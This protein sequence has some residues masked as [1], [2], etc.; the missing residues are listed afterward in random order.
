MWVGVKQLNLWLG[1]ET[2]H[3]VL[4]SY[5]KKACVK[6]LLEKSDWN[7]FLFEHVVMPHNVFEEMDLFSLNIL[8]STIKQLEKAV[9]SEEIF[10]TIRYLLYEILK[11]YNLVFHFLFMK[12]QFRHLLWT[13]PIKALLLV[14]IIIK[15]NNNYSNNNNNNLILTFIYSVSII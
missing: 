6:H 8:Q 3:L 11:S 15:N 13:V 7:Q 14:I 4:G 5:D 9:N 12:K 10:S 1:K 2:G